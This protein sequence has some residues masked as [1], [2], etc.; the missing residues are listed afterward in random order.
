MTTVQITVTNFRNTSRFE[1]CV[2][3]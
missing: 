1:N 2:K 3:L